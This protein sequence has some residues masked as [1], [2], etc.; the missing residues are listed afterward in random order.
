[1]QGLL[2]EPE[3]LD[4]GAFYSYENGIQTYLSEIDREFSDYEFFARVDY[5]EL[6]ANGYIGQDLIRLL[7]KAAGLHGVTLNKERIQMGLSPYRR[8]SERG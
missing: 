6:A 7:I 4:A 1:M 8:L 2:F 3:D 5:Q